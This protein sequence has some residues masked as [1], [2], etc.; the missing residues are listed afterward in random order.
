LQGTALRFH[1]EI[2]GDQLSSG[3]LP[4]YAGSDAT[5]QVTPIFVAQEAASAQAKER[6]GTQRAIFKFDESLDHLH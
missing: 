5:G 3:P 4:L 2:A 6:N 1:E